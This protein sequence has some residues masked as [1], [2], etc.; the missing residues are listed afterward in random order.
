[1]S[2]TLPKPGEIESQ[3]RASES[4]ATA[5]RR[6]AATYLVPE[7][8]DFDR[9]DRECTKNTKLLQRI[10]DAANVWGDRLSPAV[11]ESAIVVQGQVADGC[12]LLSRTRDQAICAHITLE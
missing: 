8:A 1:V 12:D 11:V 10:N 3:K 5:L 7:D 9:A 6:T 4:L 2:N